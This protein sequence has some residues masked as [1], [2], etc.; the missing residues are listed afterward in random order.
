MHDVANDLPPGQ[1]KIYTNDMSLARG[2]GFEN[3]TLDENDD[4][5]RTH[6]GAGGHNVGWAIDVKMPTTDGGPPPP[7]MTIHSP[8]LFAGTDCGAHQTVRR[9]RPAGFKLR[10][11][12][13]DPEVEATFDNPNDGIEVQVIGGHDNHLHFQLVV[14]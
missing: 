6:G 7:Q 14:E 8:Q 9:A 4:W 3:G 5:H 12:F 1:E 2:A 13:D 10:V 11:Y